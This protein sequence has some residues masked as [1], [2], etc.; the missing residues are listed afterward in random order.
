MMQAVM[1]DPQRGSIGAKESY[2]S[3]MVFLRTPSPDVPM[4]TGVELM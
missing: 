4:R 1:A 2:I 3:E